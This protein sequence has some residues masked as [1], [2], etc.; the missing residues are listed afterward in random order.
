MVQNHALGMHSSLYYCA[1]LQN[2]CLE[3][4]WNVEW[5]FFKAMEYVTRL[6]GAFQKC[7]IQDDFTADHAW[8]FVWANLWS[9]DIQPSNR[10]KRP[11]GSIFGIKHSNKDKDHL[12]IVR[13]I[14]DVA[15]FGNPQAINSKNA[16]HVSLNKD[17]GH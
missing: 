4:A 6:T 11:L 3:I 2:N 10:E 15:V 5:C 8:G 14:C 1:V 16:P 12:T 13:V 17:Q 9:L 7:K